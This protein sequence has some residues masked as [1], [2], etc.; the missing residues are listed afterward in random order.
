MREKNKWS[1]HK[2][3]IGF[4]EMFDY[5]I[6]DGYIGRLLIERNCFYYLHFDYAPDNSSVFDTIILNTMGASSI[7]ECKEFFERNKS[8]IEDLSHRMS[9]VN[10]KL[11][12]IW[13]IQDG[14][15]EPY[16]E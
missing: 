13:F 10:E 2:P 3:T 16:E 5:Y 9:L 8:K 11:R 12:D 4:I 1:E 7:E 14:Y 15:E 6:G